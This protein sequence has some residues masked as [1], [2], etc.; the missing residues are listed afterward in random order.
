VFTS[1]LFSSSFDGHWRRGGGVDE[2][3]QAAAGGLVQKIWRRRQIFCNR[4]FAFSLSL[5][6][7]VALSREGI[8]FSWDV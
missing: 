6:S 3:K 2:D 7:V 1:S 5:P 8:S 4:R